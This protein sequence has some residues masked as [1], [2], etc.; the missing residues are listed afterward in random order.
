M[1]VR[2][3]T[4]GC[5]GVK[6]GAA[7]VRARGRSTGRSELQELSKAELD[8]RATQQDVPG[9]SKMSRGQLVDALARTGRRR[10]KSVA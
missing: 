2:C 8:E 1:R 6:A 4:A 10:K 7:S 9:R 5:V 3:G